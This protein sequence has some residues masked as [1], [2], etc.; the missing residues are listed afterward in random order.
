[1]IAKD[2]G[3]V[4]FTMTDSDYLII[5]STQLQELPKA[6]RRDAIV[7]IFLIPREPN[8]YLKLEG[9]SQFIFSRQTSKN[10]NIFGLSIN[11]ER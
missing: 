5:C 8:I 3:V 6:P 1:M 9:K 2:L 11:P 10:I 7:L 4:F